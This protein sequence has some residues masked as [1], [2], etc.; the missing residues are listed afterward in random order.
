MGRSGA[1]PSRR[2][3]RR[4]DQ[5]RARRRTDTNCRRADRNSPM[6]IAVDDRVGLPVF[7][8]SAGRSVPRGSG[9]A[10]AGGLRRASP[11]VRSAA[12]P[13]ARSS[14]MLL[15]AIPIFG[16]TALHGARAHEPER[17]RRLGREFGHAD[18]MAMSAKVPSTP[19]LPAGSRASRDA[20]RRR[21]AWRC[22]TVRRASRMSPMCRSTTRLRTAWCSCAAVGSRR[23]QARR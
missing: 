20:S 15:V 22:P 16:M 18:L 1:V 14:V 13:V 19:V 8:R 17:R 11:V 4:R 23:R 7:E 21:S 12:G 9:V 6:T 3:H 2:S 5:C 10:G